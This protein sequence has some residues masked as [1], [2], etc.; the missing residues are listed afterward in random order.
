MAQTLSGAFRKVKSTWRVSSLRPLL[1]AYRNSVGTPLCS[2]CGVAQSAKPSEY[3]VEAAYLYNFGRFVEWP[4]KGSALSSSFT[5]CVLGEDPFGPA[6]DTTLAGETIGNQKVA[7]Q[8]NL[9]SADV[10]RLPDSVYKLVG[11]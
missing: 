3:Q 1:M 10:G 7:A 8:A 9:E 11:G 6:L 2:H 5:I 4:A